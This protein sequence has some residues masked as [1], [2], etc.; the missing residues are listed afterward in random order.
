MNNVLLKT[1]ITDSELRPEYFAS[2]MDISVKTF[3]EKVDGISEFKAS[4][5]KKLVDIL[6]LKQAD[7]MKIFFS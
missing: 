6:G 7:V 1:A 2:K 3:R 5:I 4:E